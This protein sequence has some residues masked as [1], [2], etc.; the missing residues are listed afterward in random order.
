MIEFWEFFYTVKKVIK[1]FKKV[2]IYNF[3][4]ISLGVLEI[5]G[6]SRA[7]KWSLPLT[8]CSLFADL[9]PP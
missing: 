1:S 9:S 3:S 6:Q 5:L 4:K 2:D 7:K 8:K